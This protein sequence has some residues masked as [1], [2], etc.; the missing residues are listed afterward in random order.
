MKAFWVA[1]G[2]LTL[3]VC[4]FAAEKEGE[5]Q[6]LGKLRSGQKI[7][8]VQT[9]MVQHAGTFV[10]FTDDAITLSVN[11]TELSIARNQV[12]RVSSVSHRVR[13]GV[14]MGLIGMVTLGL[15][16]G[17]RSDSQGV[18]WLAIGGL[19]AG[20]AVGVTLMPGTAPACSI[21]LTSGVPSLAFW[22][23]VSS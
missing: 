6:N 10:T 11:K 18:A 7:D 5:W 13:N 14:L 15:V 17:A 22:R 23:M 2:I 9:N 20:A 19:V 8:V 1:A 21:S 4:A 3:A 12:R 16:E